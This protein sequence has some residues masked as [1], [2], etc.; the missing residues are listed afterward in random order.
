MT[1]AKKSSENIPAAILNDETERKQWQGALNSSDEAVS[2]DAFKLFQEY[3]RDQKQ[4]AFL[5]TVL[6]EADESRMWKQFIESK[7]QTIARKARRL[8]ERCGVVIA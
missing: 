4:R 7:K 6:S 2:F 1:N 8:A 5:A 3:K